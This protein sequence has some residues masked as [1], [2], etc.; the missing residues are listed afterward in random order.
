M[1][2]CQF[3]KKLFTFSASINSSYRLKVIPRGCVRIEM[4]KFRSFVGLCIIHLCLGVILLFPF[5][6]S[7]NA[8][9]IFTALEPSKQN[10]TNTRFAIF[11]LVRLFFYYFYFSFF[12]YVSL[13]TECAW[14]CLLSH[15]L[16]F[17]VQHVH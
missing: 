2:Q 6:F 7:L 16:F 8:L 13:K 4:L 3:H 14:K 10:K 5:V 11:S 12:Q 9:Q 15:W 17:S 1:Q